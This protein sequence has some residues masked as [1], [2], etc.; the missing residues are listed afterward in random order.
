MNVAPQVW[1]DKLEIREL[2]ERSMRYLDDEAG[3]RLADLF[4]EEGTD[5]EWARALERTSAQTRAQFRVT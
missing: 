4:A 5:K 1:V 3:G 2:I